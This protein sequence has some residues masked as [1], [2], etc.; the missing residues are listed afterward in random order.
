MLVGKATGVVIWVV[1]VGTVVDDVLCLIIGFFSLP[2]IVSLSLPPNSLLQG[3]LPR[4][5]FEADVVV[6][7]VVEMNGFLFM[8]KN[9]SM[10][11]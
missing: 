4:I 8:V 7:L 3:I 1:V 10:V 11:V 9:G 2:S 5:T 6:E